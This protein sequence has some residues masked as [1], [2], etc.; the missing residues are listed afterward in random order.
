MDIRYSTNQRDVKRYTTEELRRE[1]LIEK[2]FLP[3]ELTA[4]YSH[5]DRIVVLGAMPVETSLEL[6][7]TLDC[8][9]NFGVDYFLQRRE[10]GII[11]IGGPGEVTAD[12]KKFALGHLDTLYV[13]MGTR[14]VTL[15]SENAGE[16]AKFYMCSTPAHK[17]CPTTFISMEKAAKR[18][19]GGRASSNERTINQLIHPDV[20]ETCQL[21]MG[22]TILDEGS[23]WNTMPA[24]THERRMEVYMYFKIPED[25]VVFHYMG[26]PTETRHIILHNEQAVISP[27]WSIHAGSGTASYAFIW[28]M[29]GENQEFDDMDNL[30]VMDL[31]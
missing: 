15:S 14:E 21:L 4:T 28:A 27:S 5:V 1:F 13:S 11:N 30:S 20:L 9:K 26:E 18:H 29:C 31:R 3:G 8:R 19:L 2:L 23:V 6:G 22:C 12:G 17:A 25:N 16:P 24:H 10:L 7:A